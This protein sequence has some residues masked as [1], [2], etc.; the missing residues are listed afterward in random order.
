[1]WGV[2]NPRFSPERFRD[3]AKPSSAGPDFGGCAPEALGVISGHAVH[4][5]KTTAFPVLLGCS[6]SS[7]ALSA[8]PCSPR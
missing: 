7:A 3:L 2:Q 4:S 5:H 1:M 8:L 6:S